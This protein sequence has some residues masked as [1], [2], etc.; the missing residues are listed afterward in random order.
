MKIDFPLDIGISSSINE[1][2][3]ELKKKIKRNQERFILITGATTSREYAD[4]LLSISGHQPAHHIVLHD[5]S[6][7]EIYRIE[8]EIRHLEL[9]LVVAIGGGKVSDFA[10]RLSFITNLPLLL[11]P[12]IIA[13]D[14]LISPVAVLQD[15]DR[16]VSLPGKMPD[17]VLIDIDVISS[18]PERYMRSAA[19]D[20]IT[21][22]SA[23][24]DWLR[25]SEG[26]SARMDHLAL[27]F[28]QMA[29]NQV[30]ACRDWRTRS[31]V[32]L[33]TII[34]GQMLSG[35][36]M[37]MAGSSRPCSGSEHLISHA[38]DSMQIGMDTLHGEKVGIISRYCLYLQQ[39]K[40][41]L[42]DDFFNEFKIGRTFPGCE[43]LDTTSMAEVFKVARHMR[44]G[45]ST[46]LDQFTDFE[47]SERY[48]NYVENQ[49]MPND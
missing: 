8:R 9:R 2:S 42:V 49:G 47:L 4:K 26:E 5:N 39:E 40:Q 32:F 31:T 41:P 25:A 29:A 35:I 22:L 43:N 21:N 44:P 13:N 30:L 45:R 38:L 16:S 10:K 23:T 12:T 11:V 34:Y 1:S 48:M 6:I 28:S 14:G 46:I 19:C 18:A 7:S 3:N 33:R 15:E 27:Q 17:I 36:A 37:A 20:L 24:N